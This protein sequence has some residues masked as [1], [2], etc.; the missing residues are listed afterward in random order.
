MVDVAF[1]AQL[2]KMAEEEARHAELAWAILAWYL[3]TVGRR[4]RHILQTAVDNLPKQ[5]TIEMY[6]ALALAT[7]NQQGFLS[8]NRQ[9]TLFN[10]VLAA[11]G[12]RFSKLGE[13][14][15]EQE[16]IVTNG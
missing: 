9:E 1:K 3:Q 11:V 15:N 2:L 14:F 12:M 10:T 6:D 16:L 8:R 13:P 5:L 7:A 4:G